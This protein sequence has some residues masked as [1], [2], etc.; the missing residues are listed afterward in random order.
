VERSEY[1]I[2]HHALLYVLHLL[3]RR[4]LIDVNDAHV[5]V[6]ISKGIYGLTQAGL[7]AQPL[8]F[9]SVLDSRLRVVGDE[10]HRFG[11]LDETIELF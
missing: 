3:L 2:L 1:T 8:Y 6:E 10:L 11:L 5:V 7:L 4:D 9:L